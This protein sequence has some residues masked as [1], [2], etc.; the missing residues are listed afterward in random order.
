YIIFDDWKV[1]PHKRVL[2]SPDNETVPV[3]SA[4]YR[5]LNIF[6]QNPNRVLN[7]DQ[8]MDWIAG[9]ESTPFDRSIDVQISRLR[10]KLE[11]HGSGAHL[12][13]TIRGEGYFFTA[14][15]SKT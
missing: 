7:R 4:E 1:D 11:T 2:I 5:L 14:Q 13:K 6:L 15:V 8:L 10:Q 9:R 3:S 12:I